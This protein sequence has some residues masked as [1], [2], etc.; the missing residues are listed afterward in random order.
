M[1][2]R[3]PFSFLK[4]NKIIFMIMSQGTSFKQGELLKNFYITHKKIIEYCYANIGKTFTK[5]KYKESYVDD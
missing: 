4:Q 1:V 5:W 2:G 3:R